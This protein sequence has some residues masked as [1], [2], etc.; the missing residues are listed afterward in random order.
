MTLKITYSAR[1]AN[2]SSSSARRSYGTRNNSRR[3]SIEDDKD[4][5]RNAMLGVTDLGGVDIKD[6]VILLLLLV[7]EEEVTA[8]VGL[9]WAMYV[10]S[11]PNE[12]KCNLTLARSQM[13]RI[14]CSCSASGSNY[15]IAD[16][17]YYYY[18]C[19]TYSSLSSLAYFRFFW[20]NFLFWLLPC[21]C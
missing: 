17:Y 5:S 21:C 15:V 14:V 1:D 13:R 4:G 8:N 9:C 11:L 16:Y 2:G 7:V 18:C 10:P 19:F 6:D 3:T 20:F 12:T